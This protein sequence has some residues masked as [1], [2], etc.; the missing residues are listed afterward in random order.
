MMALVASPVGCISAAGRFKR[1]ASTPQIGEE[2]EKKARSYAGEPWNTKSDR[3]VARRIESEKI[4][5]E[6]STGNALAL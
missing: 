6:T 1:K 2:T 5:C 4:I 3:M